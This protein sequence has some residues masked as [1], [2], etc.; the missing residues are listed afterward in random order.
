MRRVAGVIVLA[1]LG[2]TA[3]A[4]TAQ[5]HQGICTE[6]TNPHGQNVPPAGST[7]CPAPGAVRTRTAST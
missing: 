6:T 2:L 7:T 3:L 1:T 5:G 4:G